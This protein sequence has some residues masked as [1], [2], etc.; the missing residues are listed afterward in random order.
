MCKH[1]EIA[2]I[3]EVLSRKNFVDVLTFSAVDPNQCFLF[4]TSDPVERSGVGAWRKSQAEG[5]IHE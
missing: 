5:V 2:W 3:G 1:C 4:K